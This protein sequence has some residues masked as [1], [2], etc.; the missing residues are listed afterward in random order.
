LGLPVRSP[1]QEP[2]QQPETKPLPPPVE[3]QVSP[4]QP[5]LDLK[6]PDPPPPSP[7]GINFAITARN[8]VVAPRSFKATAYSL[9]GRTATGIQT[10]PGVLAAEPRIPPLRFVGHAKDASSSGVYIVHDTGTR[11]KGNLVDVWVPSSR[12]ARTFGRRQ[13]QLQV[14]RCGPRLQD[15]PQ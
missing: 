12:E 13:A 8:H 3:P 14:L 11:V 10:Q 4:A 15:K 9:R 2:G 7:T 6:L 1:G 5:A